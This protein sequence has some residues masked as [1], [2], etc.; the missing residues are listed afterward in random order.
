MAPKT[1]VYKNAILGLVQH[2]IL[3]LHFFR[4]TMSCSPTAGDITAPSGFGEFG[5]TV[6]AAIQR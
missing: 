6:G 5:S 3:F 2:I 1:Q 4:L